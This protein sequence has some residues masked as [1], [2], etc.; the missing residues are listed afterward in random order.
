VT[1]GRNERGQVKAFAVVIID[2][3]HHYACIVGSVPLVFLH[4]DY[5]KGTEGIR[6]IRIAEREAEKAGAQLFLT[7]GGVHNRVAKIFEYL[8]YDDFGRY[9]VKVLPNGPNGTKPIRRT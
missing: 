4:P 5:R 8:K 7:H 9:F 2:H 3:H 1:V 6:L